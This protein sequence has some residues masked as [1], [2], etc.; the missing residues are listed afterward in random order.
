MPIRPEKIAKRL[1]IA[2]YALTPQDRH[3]VYRDANGKI[4]IVI[5]QTRSVHHRR[6]AIAHA[7]GHIL[8]RHEAP[9][10]E[11]A[12][13]FGKSPRDC[14]DRAANQFAASLL[15]PTEKLRWC[16]TSGWMRNV[17]Q[18]LKTLWVPKDLLMFRYRQLIARR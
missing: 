3:S 5:D 9:A 16:L 4:S 7:L 15:V 11:S 18:V 12:E 8:M 14:S 2:I 13:S 1:G 10:L 17:D 6:F